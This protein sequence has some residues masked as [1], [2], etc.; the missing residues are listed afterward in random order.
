MILIDV[1]KEKNLESALKKFKYK[2]LKTK[3]NEQI[4]E[5]QEF[6]KPSVSKRS[7]KLKAIYRQWIKSNE[8]KSN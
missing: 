4:R 2:V 5:R 7:K 3:Q 1:K 8:E 6:V